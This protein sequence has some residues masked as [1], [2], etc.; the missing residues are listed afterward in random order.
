[1]TLKFMGKHYPLP[2]DWT[3][4]IFTADIKFCVDPSGV[5]N[6]AH[7]AYKP[8]HWVDGAW[9]ELEFVPV[10]SLI[11]LIQRH[12]QLQ[13]DADK[14][15]DGMALALQDFMVEYRKIHGDKRDR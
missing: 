10:Q 2:K 13:K 14:L 11:E 4:E 8:C 7:P 1:M 5:V 15:L 9:K 12:R 3:G 6:I